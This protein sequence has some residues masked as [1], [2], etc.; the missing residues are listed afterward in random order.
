MDI[1]LVEYIYC[2]SYAFFNAP[3]FPLHLHRIPYIRL[4]S[5]YKIHA[6]AA[7]ARKN[8]QPLSEYLKGHRKSSLALHLIHI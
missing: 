7:L 4:E 1:H 2:N 3:A 8:D 5:M 6:R